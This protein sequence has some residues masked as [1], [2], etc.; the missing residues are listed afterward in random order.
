M[1]LLCGSW[2]LNSDHQAWQEMPV[3]V[4]HLLDPGG[5]FPKM[6]NEFL[7]GRLGEDSLFPEAVGLPEVLVGLRD[8]IKGGLGTVTQG[9]SV[10]PG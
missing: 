7:M 3:P 2:E 10:V 5:G 1:W 4:S 8:G 6:V 9:A